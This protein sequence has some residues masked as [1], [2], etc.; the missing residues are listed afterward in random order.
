M[1]NTQ[2]QLLESNGMQIQRILTAMG[3]NCA[4]QVASTNDLV[5]KYEYN[6]GRLNDF[7][8]IKKAVEVM[9]ICLHKEYLAKI[10]I[11]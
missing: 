11:L 3:I 6:L 5:E 7:K 2:Q 1:K 10:Y 8:K 4:L 9:T